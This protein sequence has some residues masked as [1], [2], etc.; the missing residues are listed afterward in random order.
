MT[1]TTVCTW[2]GCSKE[3]VYILRD[4]NGSVCEK[5]C[6][7]HYW[8]SMRLLR[9]VF[10]EEGLKSKFETEKGERM[11]LKLP[12]QKLVGSTGQDVAGWMDECK[13]L[14]PGW[15]HV[16]ITTINAKPASVTRLYVD[17]ARRASVADENG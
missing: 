1:E 14:S 4:K 17:G 8:Q 10:R 7:E 9:D 11:I 3:V 5:L 13:D 2:E 12:D 16:V 6:P 15:H